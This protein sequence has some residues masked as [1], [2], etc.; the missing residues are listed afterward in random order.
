MGGGRGAV[1]VVLAAVVVAGVVTAAGPDRMGS[2][3]P[4]P[5]PTE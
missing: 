3:L 2:A 1:T 5:M 4:A